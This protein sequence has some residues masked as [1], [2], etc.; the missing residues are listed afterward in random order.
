MR[1]GTLLSVAFVFAS[2][3]SMAADLFHESFSVPGGDPSDCYGRNGNPAFPPGWTRFNVDGRTPDASVSY[4]NDAWIV[5]E[6]FKFDGAQC[7][8]FSTSWYAP[9]GPADDWMWSPAI[10]LPAAGGM[11]RW[12]AVSYD[13]SFRDSY[14]V[15]VKTGSAPTQANQSAST[16]VYSNGAEEAAWTSRQVDLSTYG[17]QTIYLGFRNNSN[18]K[19]LLL[20]DD[21]LVKSMEADILVEA[22]LPFVG[23]Y[24]RVPGGESIVSP[25]ALSVSNVGGVAV[26]HVVATAT[27]LLGGTD[28]GAASSSTPLPSL[29]AGES[30]ALTFDTPVVFAGDGTWTLRYDASMDEVDEDVANNTV[31]VAGP[32]IGGSELARWE[33]AATGVLGIGAGNG[34]ELGVML[35]VPSGAYYDGARFAMLPIAP[36]DGGTPPTPNP[37]PGFDFVLNLRSFDAANH[38]PGDVID[39]TVPVP[40][41]Y[42][43]G[44]SYDVA[45]AGGRRWLPAGD[46]VL[47]AIEPVGGPTLPLPLHDQRFVPGSTWVIWP[48]SPLGGWGHNEDFGANFRKTYEMSLLKGEQSIFA[49]GFDGTAPAP[50]AFRAS[51][52]PAPRVMPGTTR[53]PPSSRLATPGS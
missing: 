8:A 18:D 43:E 21:V 24:A 6:D 53:T 26:T 35:S 27:P 45:F 28:G 17:G 7:A 40:C 48:T 14:E 51:V 10:V 33:G 38:R 16:V 41:A 19:F 9:P 36:D 5:R 39:T 1:A 2:P 23:E 32:V 29:G 44:G 42:D 34:G 13:P 25:P 3:W 47:T 20:I 31:E 37:C 49:D 30:Q 15:R 12:R 46:Y 11:L 4:V 52:R 22:P 50:V